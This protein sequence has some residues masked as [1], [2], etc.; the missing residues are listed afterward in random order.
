MPDRPYSTDALRYEVRMKPF[1]PVGTPE[2]PSNEDMH[3]STH[4][5]LTAD[6]SSIFND[7]DSQ[8][9]L[10]KIALGTMKN[11]T[12]EEGKY[13]G[14]EAYWKKSCQSMLLSIISTGVFAAG[15]RAAMKKASVDKVGDLGQ[16]AD[17]LNKS[18]RVELPAVDK[19]YHVWW[20]VP[21]LVQI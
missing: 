4:W 19:R 6:I 1:L 7:V 20:V 3:D 15:L 14:V 11:A 5:E 21:K 2:L 9:K 18:V 8:I 13:K 12:P 10:A 17:L 16:R